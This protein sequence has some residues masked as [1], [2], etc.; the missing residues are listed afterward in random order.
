MQYLTTRH[1]G[2][3]A[4]DARLGKDLSQ[5]QLGLKIGASRFWVAEFE[6]GKPRAEFELVLKA[7]RALGLVLT[8]QPAP[9]AKQ[10]IDGPLAQFHDGNTV[11]LSAILQQTATP[12]MA[13]S[14]GTLPGT[15]KRAAMKRAEKKPVSSK[16][17]AVGANSVKTRRK[18]K[19]SRSN[20]T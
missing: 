2:A 8:I 1:V 15:L 10:P 13:Q 18:T 16:V 11:N 6:R 14:K 17:A 7:L 12:L 19:N 3:L 5:T 9:A 4:R 20:R